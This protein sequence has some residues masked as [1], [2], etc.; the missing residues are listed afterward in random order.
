MP[1]LATLADLRLDLVL[2][3]ELVA[4]A[5]RMEDFYE[6]APTLARRHHRMVSLTFACFDVLHLAGHSTLPLPYED[7]R[8]LLARLELPPAACVVPS[9]AGCDSGELLSACEMYGVEGV[10]LKKRGSLYTPGRRSTAWRK[11]KALGWKVEH[12][13]RRRPQR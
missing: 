4:A 13:G 9:F 6:V 7:R 11:V 2:D 12:S 1:E 10:V 5:G 3:G 8:L